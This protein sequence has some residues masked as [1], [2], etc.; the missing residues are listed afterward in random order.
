MSFDPLTKLVYVPVI[1]A[2]SVWVDLLHN[3]AAVTYLDG[4]FTTNGVIADD[5]YDAAAMRD[6]YGPMPDLVTLRAAH[7]GP[8]VRELLRA[9]DPVAQTT[10]WEVQTSSGMR[11]Y[12]G[13]VLSTQGNLVLQGRGDGT[14]W[15]YSAD[16]GRILKVIQ[17]GSHIMAAPMTYAVSGAQ[18]IAVQVGYGGTAMT[19]GPLPPQ[20]AALHYENVNRIL[21]FRL[22]GSAVPMP[23]PAPD[24]DFPQPP[25]QS[26]SVAEIRLGSIKFAEQCSRCHVFG[27][28]ITPDLRKLPPG[29]HAAFQDIVLRGLFAPQGMARFDDVLSP[30]DVTAIHAYLIDQARIISLK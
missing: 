30:A 14:L 27:P 4:F 16:T 6:L 29:I 17:T 11:G 26:A 19:V 9:W 2:P 12:D 18:Y 21:A 7:H 23:P 15:I 13:G 24:T 28:S 20:S 3:N 22:G 5:S 10:K 25:P 8:L 1:D